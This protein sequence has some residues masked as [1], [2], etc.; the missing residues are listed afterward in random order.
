[1]RRRKLGKP[2]TLIHRYHLDRVKTAE[3][4]LERFSATC[5]KTIRTLSADLPVG[6]SGMSF[7]D[8]GGEA[9]WVVVGKK[10]ALTDGH[11]DRII[12]H[13]LGHMVAAWERG[14]LGKVAYRRLDFADDL[15]G[16]EENFAE[17]FGV[18]LAR[19]I[20]DQRLAPLARIT[21]L[22]HRK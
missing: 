7:G 5:G 13:E 3:E 8:E 10:N 1:M 20:A 11:R 18:R 15:T 6:C 16:P 9:L 21:G 22:G 14:E 12:L 17:T 4:A 2:Q 19:V